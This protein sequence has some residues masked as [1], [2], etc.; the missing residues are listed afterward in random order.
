MKTIVTMP[1]D[2]IGKTVLPEAVRVL[3]AS[4]FKAEYIHGDIG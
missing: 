3:D 1:G 2:G 4:G